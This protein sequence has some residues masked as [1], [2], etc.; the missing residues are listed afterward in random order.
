MAKSRLA[1]LD[2]EQHDE[3]PRDNQC[4][5]EP[6]T[7]VAS[8]SSPQAR[9]ACLQ[10][11]ASGRIESSSPRGASMLVPKVAT[12]GADRRIA[13]CSYRTDATLRRRD[14]FRSR[15]RSG[16]AI[17]T[18]RLQQLRRPRGGDCRRSPNCA[19]GT[20]GGCWQTTG[21]SRRR[22]SRGEDRDNPRRG[23]CDPRFR[24]EEQSPPLS[25]S[26]RG[27]RSVRRDGVRRCNAPVEGPGQRSS[28]PSSSGRWREL[29]AFISFAGVGSPTLRAAARAANTSDLCS[30]LAPY[31][32]PPSHAWRP[33]DRGLAGRDPAADVQSG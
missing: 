2:R 28:G 17:A 27:R 3:Y 5:T 7:P 29:Q 33:G 18:P 4:R 12:N 15:D 6:V 13:R 10:L 24:V 26:P 11:R 31:D 19:L 20:T 25:A 21:R 8:P 23:P 14:C 1:S 9:I 16:P 22:A 32:Q 30:P